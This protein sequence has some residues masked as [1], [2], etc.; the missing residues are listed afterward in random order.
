MKRDVA[1]SSVLLGLLLILTLGLSACGSSSNSAQPVGVGATSNATG[2]IDQDQTASITASVSND[3]KNAGVTWSVS[4]T[5]GSQGTLSSQTTT[6]VTYNAPI[7]VTTAFVAIV[8]ATSITDTTKSASVHI[9]VNPPPTIT[10]ATLPAATAGVFYVTALTESGGTG[11]YKWSVTSGSLASLGLSLDAG[12]GTITGTPTGA[13]SGSVT[14][15][16]TDAA[17]LSSTSPAITVTVN[18]PAKLVVTTA[19]LP[20]AAIAVAYSQTVTAGG[21][22]QPYTFAITSG[23]LPAGLTL[24]GSTG[25]ISGTP[26]GTAGTSNFT[27][28]V[29]DS[30]TPTHGSNSANLSIVVSLAPVS[31]TTTSLNEGLI[32]YVY[33]QTLQ[34]SGGSPPY[35]WSIIAGTLPS[36]LVLNPNT[37]TITGTPTTAG[38]YNFAVQVTDS[39]TPTRETATANLSIIINGALAIATKSMPGGSVGTAYS[40]TLQATGG[41]PPYTW[42]ITSGSLPAGLTL[43][44]AS[45]DISG[46]PTATGTSNF[47]VTVA[48]SESPQVTASAGLGI[49]IAA[50]NCT[51]DS[52]LKGN[53]AFVSGGWSGSTT[54]TSSAGSFL[55][56]G[57]GNIS[58]GLIDVAD[59]ASKSKPESGTF[60]GTYCVTSNNLATIN[61]TYGGALSGGNT[62]IAALDSGDSN[63]HIISYDNSTVKVSGL[64][65]QQNTAAFATSKIDGNYA[66]GLVGADQL[67]N[68]Y[69]V[70]GEFN[71]NGSGTLSGE[72]DSDDGGV[73]HNAQTL[74]SSD[75]TVAS[76]GRGTAT[77]TSSSGNAD[78]VFY[79]V[80][81]SEMLMMAFDTTDVS[82]IIL[83]G[84]VLEQTG[85]LTD[86]SLDG[87]SVIELQSLGSNGN[88]PSV[89]AGLITTDGNATYTLTADQNAGGTMNALN[90]SGS[91]S[92]SSTGRAS[93]T[94]TGGGSSQVLY[95]IAQNQAFLIGTNIGVDSGGMRP[96]TGNNFNVSSLLGNFYGGSQRPENSN[97]DVEADSVTFNG[98]GTL[99]GTSDTN[100]SG[101][102]QSAPVSGSYLVSANGRV[103]VSQSGTP[104]IYLYMISASEFVALPVNSLQNTDTNPTLID[105]HQ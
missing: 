81:S 83:T 29:T 57:N 71:S 65:R 66:F 80:S 102:P 50:H 49:S 53:Y 104:V 69:A 12:T 3:S 85:T 58:S 73:I 51:N 42:S 22:V 24:N 103:V 35:T 18:P 92:V 97:V 64:L 9:P 5:N 82:P 89:T 4:G 95:L 54:A 20:G 68:R 63:G 91:Y 56:D 6:S 8:T 90:T 74:S 61:L 75:F 14:F 44:S 41:L 87:V 70:A 32:G 23:S 88:I 13:G 31:V 94:P 55:A 60:T 96:Q 34:A 72:D 78:Y 99:S 105:F 28:T 101:G 47:T 79:V 86:A 59:Q 15:G 48:D 76:T 43:N 19:S 40:S 16:V 2:G 84:Q 46:T 98:A 38:T 62:F 100:N 17:K 10:T 11:P 39:T 21:G 93:L 37:G 26:N 77:I 1:V 52:T 27:V 33:N 30:Q 36:G 67:G 7:S 25:V 45:G